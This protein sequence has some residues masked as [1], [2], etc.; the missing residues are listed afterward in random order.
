[1]KRSR[2]R[3]HTAR[4]CRKA[5]LLSNIECRDRTRMTV[6][7]EWPFLNVVKDLINADGRRRLSMESERLGQAIRATRC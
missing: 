1:M 3:L 7:R 6:F 4:C 2:L 5:K